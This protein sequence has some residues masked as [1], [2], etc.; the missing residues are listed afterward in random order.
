MMKLYKRLLLKKL[1][2]SGWDL[3]SQD[4]DTDWWLEEAWTIKS[5][6]NNWGFELLINRQ[7]NS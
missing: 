4:S 2:E 6:H 5:I 3:I 1:G 7:T